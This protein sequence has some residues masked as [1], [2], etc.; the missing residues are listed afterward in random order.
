[1]HDLNIETWAKKGR[2][3]S[4]RFN[5]DIPSRVKEIAQSVETFAEKVPVTHVVLNN[6]YEDQGQRMP[7]R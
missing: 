7:R 3:S 1:M 2:T 4:H 6:N 5:Y